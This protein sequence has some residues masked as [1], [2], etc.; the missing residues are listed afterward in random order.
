MWLLPRADLTEERTSSRIFSN[1][2]TPALAGL[3]SRRQA[4]HSSNSPR[5]RHNEG[6]WEAP[7]RRERGPVKRHRRPGN[8][9]RQLVAAEAKYR[10]LVEQIP[11]IVYTAEFGEEG[12]WSYVSP[13]IESI[14]GFT[15]REW[16]TDAALWYRHL[17]PEDR[18]HAMAQERQSRDS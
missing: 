9:D 6:H 10:T 13:R 2:V 11:A 12:R 17:H 5:C 3:A 16:M 8:V 1:V 15:P 18:A 4:R 14:L 7:R